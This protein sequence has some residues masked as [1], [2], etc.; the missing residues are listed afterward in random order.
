MKT[1]RTPDRRFENLP[2]YDFE[3]HYVDIDGLRM[4]YVDEGPR[5]ANPVL[6]MHGEPSWSYLYRHMIPPLA[7]AGLRVLAPDLIGFGRSDKPTKKT[8]DWIACHTGCG[9]ST[10]AHLMQVVPIY[11]GYPQRGLS[12]IRLQGDSSPGREIPHARNDE[13]R[14]LDDIQDSISMA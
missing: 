8:E 1:L 14:I 13:S 12:T 4:H 10:L 7:A 3:P 6:L 11:P 2:G 9:I 5:E